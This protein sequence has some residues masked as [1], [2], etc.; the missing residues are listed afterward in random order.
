MD[1]SFPR[2]MLNSPVREGALDAEIFFERVI[3]RLDASHEAN[4]AVPVVSTW[5]Q[6]LLELKSMGLGKPRRP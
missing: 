5:Y 3:I 2:P 4:L 1:L 6:K